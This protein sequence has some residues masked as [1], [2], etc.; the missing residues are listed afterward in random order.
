MRF[1]K[2]AGLVGFEVETIDRSRDRKTGES[3]EGFGMISF[4]GEAVDGANS[5]KLEF[6]GEL[7]RSGFVLPFHETDEAMSVLEVEADE[8]LIYPRHLLE[9]FGRLGNNFPPVGGFGVMNI[10]GDHATAGGLVV[11]LEKKG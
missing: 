9:R 6:L 8:L 4:P 5:G 10:D 7:C 3:V 2:D 11:R 1:A